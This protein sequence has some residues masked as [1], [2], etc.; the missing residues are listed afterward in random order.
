MV[1]SFIAKHPN[2]WCII[3]VAIHKALHNTQAF[4]VDK[5]FLIN[6]ENVV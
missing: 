1:M 3:K 5:Y 6:I 4:Y 2:D